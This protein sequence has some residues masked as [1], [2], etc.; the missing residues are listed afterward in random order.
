[1]SAPRPGLAEVAVTWVL[2]GLVAAAT[3]LTYARVPV[4]ELYHVSESGAAGGFGRALVFI[5]FPTALAA[6][7]V[8]PV[9]L[10]RLLA[11]SRNRLLQ[12]VFGAV[13]A[14]AVVLCL[15][16]AFPGVVDQA[17]L[18]AKPVNAVPALGVAIALAFTVLAARRGGLGRP[19]RRDGWD[20]WRALLAAVLAVASLPWIWAELGFY[21]SGA[22]L[23][24][25]VFL[26]AEP[27]PE[28]GDPGLRAVHL[29]R[30]HGFDGALLAVTA[31]LLSRVIRDVRGRRLRRALA[32][33]VA[34]LLVYGLLNAAQDFWLEQVVKRGSTDERLPSF[35][36]PGLTWA[37]ACM[38]AAAVA[39]Y[40]FGTRRL[41]RVR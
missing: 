4:E 10:D 30:H 38:V 2:Y 11:T 16:T 5:N 40:A 7:A 24:G 18:D 21:I 41:E 14:L 26:A 32:L 6:I 25:D 37:W 15:T 17:D 23:L 3:T 12:G 8:L 36:R 34:A 35:L 13:A 27:R 33:A 1:M 28:P 29:G 20:R 39:V 9:V 19:A 31:I 22:P